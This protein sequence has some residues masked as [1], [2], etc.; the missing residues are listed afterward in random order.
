MGMRGGAVCHIR[1]ISAGVRAWLGFQHLAFSLELALQGQGF[2]GEGAG[3][4][5]GAGVFVA[6]RVKSGGGQG[7]FLAPERL[8]R[9]DSAWW[10]T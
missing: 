7:V 2:G 9:E 10:K 3:G 8:T 6:Q 5:D 1:S 4:G